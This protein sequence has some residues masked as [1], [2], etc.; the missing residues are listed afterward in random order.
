[1]V[2]TSCDALTTNSQNTKNNE[3][4]DISTQKKDINNIQ[5]DT[6]VV[7]K[8][9]VLHSE[10]SI[11]WEPRIIKTPVS[12]PRKNFYFPESNIQEIKDYFYNDVDT[13]KVKEKYLDENNYIFRGYVQYTDNVVFDYSFIKDKDGYFGKTYT[14]TS[15][16]KESK[17]FN[18]FQKSLIYK[19]LEI[20]EV[21]DP[22]KF[23]QELLESPEITK[24]TGCTVQLKKAKYGI[25]DLTSCKEDDATVLALYNPEL[26]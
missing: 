24:Y 11:D 16:Y 8:E 3:E 17:N 7:I 20:S 26:E 9:D 15:N 10:N 25:I 6:L 14:L 23:F 18:D 2:L 19:V 1:M 22:Q 12:Q 5:K 21:D 13:S 4:I